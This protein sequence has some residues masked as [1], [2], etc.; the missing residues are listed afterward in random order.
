MWF[1]WTH[2]HIG[3]ARHRWTE[4]TRVPR[5]TEE[6]GW[7]LVVASCRR[8]RLPHNK[9]AAGR[10]E[11]PFCENKARRR[12]LVTT[13][14]RCRRPTCPSSAESI[15]ISSVINSHSNYTPCVEPS[16]LVGG[17]LCSTPAAVRNT[18]ADLAAFSS[19]WALRTEPS[20]LL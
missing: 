13:Y 16:S 18:F 20:R 15:R 8:R 7:L 14:H 9:T 6:R 12:C 11:R 3:P 19:P 17:R 1:V 4:R 2:T 10:Y 5:R